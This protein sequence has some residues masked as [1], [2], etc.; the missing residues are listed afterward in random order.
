MILPR[1]GSFRCT[2][3]TLEP[4]GYTPIGSQSCLQQLY[5]ATGGRP[6][7]PHR[8]GIT[9]PYSSLPLSTR[10]AGV[11][12]ALGDALRGGVAPYH[13]PRDGLGSFQHAA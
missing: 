6:L 8:A 4:L 2:T 1:Q 7:V 11:L 13:A 10:R 9:Q 5:V 3:P 12:A